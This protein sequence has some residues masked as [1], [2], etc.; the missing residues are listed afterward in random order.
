MQIISEI[1]EVKS[2]YHTD[3]TLVTEHHTV[4]INYLYLYDLLRVANKMFSL[5]MRTGDLKGCKVKLIKDDY[6]LHLQAIK[7]NGIYVNAIISN[8]GE[9]V[10]YPIYGFHYESQA[11][12]S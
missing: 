10:V 6:S 9:R 2:E 5:N 3:C 8:S 11:F 1:I 12:Q 7:I 4:Y